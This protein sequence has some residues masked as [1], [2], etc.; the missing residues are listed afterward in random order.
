MLQTI[1]KVAITS[2]L[3]VAAAEAA[4]RSIILGAIIAS[5]P[6]TS[7]LA[8]AW[9]YADTGDTAKIAAFSTGVF[10]MV[11]PSLILFLVL[12]FLLNRGWTF[13]PGLTVSIALTTAGYLAM[14][15]ILK[16]FGIEI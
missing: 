1:L 5:L 10:W 11:L 15:E 6:L 16:R 8:M 4:K 14:I 3:G 7:L 12:P 9:L 2:L 13:L